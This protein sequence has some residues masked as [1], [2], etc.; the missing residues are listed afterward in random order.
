MICFGK[1]RRYKQLMKNA[2]E[3]PNHN[4]S[5]LVQFALSNPDAIPKLSKKLTKYNIQKV[6]NLKKKRRGGLSKKVSMDQSN[7]VILASSSSSLNPKL[8]VLV[9]DARTGIRIFREL[10]E[11]TQEEYLLQHS[12]RKLLDNL[13]HQYEQ[14]ILEEHFLLTDILLLLESVP[15]PDMVTFQIRTKL[16]NLVEY[17]HE[18]ESVQRKIRIGAM[19]VI[20]RWSSE[21]KVESLLSNLWN[22]RNEWNDNEI[23]YQSVDN[24]SWNDH[25][26]SL[27][28]IQ[29]ELKNIH[30][31]KAALHCIGQTAKEMKVATIVKLIEPMLEFFDKNK[32]WNELSFAS[33]CVE[34]ILNYGWREKG[35]IILSLL[36]PHI[37]TLEDISSKSLAV[38]LVGDLSS[39]MTMEATQ[40]SS[41]LAT[42]SVLLDQLVLSQADEDAFRREIMYALGKISD[43]RQRFCYNNFDITNAVFSAIDRVRDSQGRIYVLDSLIAVTTTSSFVAQGKSYPQVI[44]RHLFKELNDSSQDEESIIRCLRVAQNL[45]KESHISEREFDQDREHSIDSNVLASAISVASYS[46]KQEEEIHFALVRLVEKM[47]TNS[48]RV[49]SELAKLY[50]VLLRSYQQRELAF[51]FP[52][53]FHLTELK[54]EDSIFK[55]VINTLVSIYMLQLAN[56][57]K[58][59][60]LDELIKNSIQSQIDAKYLHDDFINITTSFIKQPRAQTLESLFEFAQNS[61]FITNNFD[62]ENVARCFSKIDR[63]HIPTGNIYESIMREYTDFASS[64]QSRSVKKQFEWNLPLIYEE[65]SPTQSLDLQEILSVPDKESNQVDIESI[66]T[67]LDSIPFYSHHIEVSLPPISIKG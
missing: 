46:L 56:E 9:D 33:T 5:S 31:A 15:H 28:D 1:T 62:R 45:S 67:T 51:V 50:S 54:S 34:N 25:K 66:F 27:N 10:I 17:S 61:N 38:R 6:K 49:F 12:L 4:I 42:T 58:N 41:I 30:V 43:I 55:S 22:H 44:L 13:F 40:G 24:I 26:V 23:L 16:R 60:E 47:N 63:L 8:C 29:S 2:F 64:R 11:A 57:F 35:F 14:V 21:V 3:H 19:R 48:P 32:A 52:S 59:S 39:K 36:L 18:D 20:S 37:S 65:N 53:L 7:G